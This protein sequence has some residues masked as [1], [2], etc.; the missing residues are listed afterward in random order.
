MYLSPTG[1]VAVGVGDSMIRVWNT[2]KKTNPYDVSTFWQGIKSKVTA[3]SLLYA[4]L[5]SVLVVVVDVGLSSSSF[6][7]SSSALCCCFRLACVVD[8]TLKSEY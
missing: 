3:V 6:F 8:W 4:F 2:S 5:L 1:R 7:L